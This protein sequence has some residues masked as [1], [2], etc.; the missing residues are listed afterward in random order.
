VAQTLSQTL[1]FMSPLGK[2]ILAINI[3]SR[4][5]WKAHNECR[6]KVIENLNDTLYTFICQRSQWEL[7]NKLYDKK[8]KAG[9]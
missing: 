1:I 5:N 7:K 8:L 4:L 3:G 6:V 2:N 9:L